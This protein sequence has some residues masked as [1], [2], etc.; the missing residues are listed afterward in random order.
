[1]AQYDID[2]P[3]FGDEIALEPRRT[4]VMA[5]LS[6][7]CGLVCVVPGMGVVA[8]IFGIASLVGI[9]RSRGRVGGTGLAIAGLI[10]GLLFSMVWIG[11]LYVVSQGMSVVAQNLVRPTNEAFVAADNGDFSKIKALFSARAQERMRDEDLAKF[12]D[13]VKAQYGAFKRVPDSPIEYWQ[14][15]MVVGSEMSNFQGRQD[16]IPLPVEYEK[17]WV[18]LAIQV[19]NTRS[20][21]SNPPGPGVQSVIPVVNL[22]AA[23]PGNT[24]IDLYPAHAVPA[25]LPPD[26]AATL[27]PPTPAPGN[28]GGDPPPEKK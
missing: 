2:G 13:A 1:M 26:P 21:R 4:S 22:Y 11:I 7:V 25:L 28:N 27:P 12:H 8:A 20:G 5:I 9:S 19:D 23:A 6:L 15:L 14:R 16:I 10:L 18:L 17:G 3:E 24:R